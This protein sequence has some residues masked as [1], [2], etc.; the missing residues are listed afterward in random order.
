MF[1]NTYVYYNDIGITMGETSAT[2]YRLTSP[3]GHVVSA[4][5][6]REY[7]FYSDGEIFRTDRYMVV[8]FG[9]GTSGIISIN[10]L[11]TIVNAYAIA[12]N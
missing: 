12:I 5:G 11:S 6:Y 10:D 7:N 4:F 1:L 2:M 3:N 8:S 9:N